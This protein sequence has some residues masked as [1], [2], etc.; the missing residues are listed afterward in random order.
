MEILVSYLPWIQITLAIILSVAILLQQRGASVGG[1]FGGS[2]GTIHYERR[3]FEKT[4][5]DI[6]IV[7]AVLFVLSAFAQLFIK[8]ETPTLA[9]PNIEVGDTIIEDVEVTS[10]T[11][12][13]T[14]EAEPDF[15]SL[16]DF[17]Q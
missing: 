11:I 6:T 9:Q 10:E 4:L 2:E 3:G 16:Q 7:L 17:A 12:P 8:I 14:E 1:V 5:F 13:D 15:P